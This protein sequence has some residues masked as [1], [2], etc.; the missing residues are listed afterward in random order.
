MAKFSETYVQIAEATA[1]S[2]DALTV[3]VEPMSDTSNYNSTA[4]SGNVKTIVDI[5]TKSLPGSWDEDA[6]ISETTFELQNLSA[7][8]SA[9]S[10]IKDV[11]ISNAPYLGLVT[12]INNFVVNNVLGVDGYESDLQTFIDSDCTWDSD[13]SSGA[14]APTSW[15]TLM[16][17]AGFDVVDTHPDNA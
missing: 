12:A 4:L 15:I 5:Q 14:G 10:Q 9:W 2:R 11:S 3:A 13:P 1:A 16:Q 8:N 7:A 6:T 17:A